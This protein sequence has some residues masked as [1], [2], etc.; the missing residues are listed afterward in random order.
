MKSG[1]KLGQ[2]QSQTPISSAFW[3]QKD[4]GLK[5]VGSQKNKLQKNFGSKNRSQKKK[6]GSKII[7]GLSKFGSKNIGFTKI[8]RKET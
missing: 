8:L 5:S 6:F 4:F 2:R 3:V 1:N 7:F